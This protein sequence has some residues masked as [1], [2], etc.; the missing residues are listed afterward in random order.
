M[1]RFPPE[2]I[3]NACPLVLNLPHR[4]W[5]KAGHQKLEIKCKYPG[6]WCFSTCF[7]NSVISSYMVSVLCIKT[8][9]CIWTFDDT[10]LKPKRI[11]QGYITHNNLSRAYVLETHTGRET[12]KHTVLKVEVILNKLLYKIYA[13]SLTFELKFWTLIYLWRPLQRAS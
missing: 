12:C 6:R 11:L 4:I 5:F 1:L 13:K 8:Y 3:T 9:Q 10:L 2:M 7:C